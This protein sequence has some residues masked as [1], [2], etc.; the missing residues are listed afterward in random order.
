MS[1]NDYII[2]TSDIGSNNGELVI[3]GDL[4]IDNTSKIYDEISALI[5]NSQIRVIR[6]QNISNIDLS[7]IQVLIS[8]GQTIKKNN[9]RVSI[10]TNLD[11]QFAELLENTGITEVFGSISKG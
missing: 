10:E 6:I 11:N 8:L 9:M 4:S 3:Q 5:T 2:Q 7:F 1:S